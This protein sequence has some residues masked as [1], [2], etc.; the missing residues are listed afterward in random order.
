MAATA[1]PPLHCIPLFVPPGEER[2]L[3]KLADGDGNIRHDGRKSKQTGQAGGHR[4]RAGGRQAKSFGQTGGRTDGQE[5]NSA[6]SFVTG[7]TDRRRDLIR[8]GRILKFCCGSSSSSCSF[9][10]IGERRVVARGDR[11][12]FGT[13]LSSYCKLRGSRP[14]TRCS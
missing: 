3:L 10:L 6:S 4:A 1:S 8:E 5:N 13:I 12:L 7:R 14:E 2:I 9:I 11:E